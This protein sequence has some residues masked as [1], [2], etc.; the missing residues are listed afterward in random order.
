MEKKKKKETHVDV[1][2]LEGEIDD[3]KIKCF[4]ETNEFFWDEAT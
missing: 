4:T 3:L 2:I 1:T